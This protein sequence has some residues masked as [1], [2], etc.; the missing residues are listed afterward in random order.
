MYVFISAE[1]FWELRQLHSI[2]VGSIM[3]VSVEQHSALTNDENKL[4]LV[5]T[6]SWY[7]SHSQ[8]VK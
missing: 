2:T 5:A 6:S 4:N 3:C 7:N 8:V 1:T